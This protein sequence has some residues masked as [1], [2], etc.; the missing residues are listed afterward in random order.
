MAYRKGGGTVALVWPGNRVGGTEKVGLQEEDRGGCPQS[1]CF[2][3][4]CLMRQAASFSGSLNCFKSKK[5]KGK[6]TP[7]WFASWWGVLLFSIKNGNVSQLKME[8]PK[9]PPVPY[10][11]TSGNGTQHLR[12]W[13]W[14]WNIDAIGYEYVS[15]QILSPQNVGRF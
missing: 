5:R 1:S 15:K 11:K 8:I 13:L 2:V 4:C 10:Q 14:Y 12:A 3:H 6:F 9:C 7:T